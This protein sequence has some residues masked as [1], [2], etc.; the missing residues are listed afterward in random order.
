[1]LCASA[2]EDFSAEM[3]RFA[4]PAL[5]PPDAASDEIVSALRSKSPAALT[6]ARALGCVH[7]CFESPT[8][9]T[10]DRYYGVAPARKAIS[11][12]IFERERVAFRLFD[13][14]LVSGGETS[15]TCSPASDH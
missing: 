11:H 9:T 14:T 13:L 6:L 3:G 2:D 5:V 4:R 1:M 10:R 7:R 15:T 12:I 8:A